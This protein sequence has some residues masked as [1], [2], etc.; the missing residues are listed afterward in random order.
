MIFGDCDVGFVND[1]IFLM[2]CTLICLT[3]AYEPKLATGSPLRLVDTATADTN[4]SL[5]TDFFFSNTT[6]NLNATFDKKPT[7]TG[8]LAH[9]IPSKLRKAIV[10][11]FEHE[12]IKD[13]I[14]LCL[15]QALCT[16]EQVLH[17]ASGKDWQFRIKHRR[18]VMHFWQVYECIAYNRPEAC[19]VDGHWSQWG[20]WSN[21]SV[22][23]G[24][25]FSERHRTCDQP[26]PA[27]YGKFCSGKAKER[28]PCNQFCPKN[29]TAMA[30]RDPLKMQALK[31]LHNISA[32]Y[33]AVKD[34]CSKEHCTFNE[35]HHLIGDEDV[36][37]KYWLAM[38]CIERH[39]GCP[40]DGEWSA[41]Q[42]WSSCSSDCG[43]GQRFRVRRCND[44]PPSNG[45]L[46]CEGP[47]I[48]EE[49]CLGTNCGPT[50]ESAIA[51]FPLWT[52]WTDWTP[53]PAKTCDVYGTE[54]STRKCVGLTPNEKCNVGDGTFADK[55]V[56]KRPCVKV[57]CLPSPT[58]AKPKPRY[59]AER[60]PV[61][62]FSEFEKMVPKRYHR[63]R[64]K[65]ALRKRRLGPH[66]AS[67]RYQ[68]L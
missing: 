49:D 32:A 46:P 58:T 54:Y 2:S 26:A 38:H 61:P 63:R 17:G 27:N 35:V 20:K 7:A 65:R 39:V 29:F 40:I 53:C 24:N 4:S 30:G 36:A 50:N 62:V 52:E 67:L 16:K 64:G 48:D 68:E 31:S 1:F 15:K 25:G 45:G 33:P 10:S 57:G 28:Q 66:G 11:T 37:D 19:P 12:S 18:G 9:K 3:A 42:P 44:P 13:F 43:I 51:L 34:V 23:C 5:E 8:F 47:M 41:W 14:K 21:C 60:K 6:D 56:R 55:L 59:F 22:A